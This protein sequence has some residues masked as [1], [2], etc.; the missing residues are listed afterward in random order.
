MRN[1]ILCIGLLGTALFGGAFVISFANPLLVERLGREVVRIEV[2]R[3][4]GA[5]VESLSNSN[6]V[7][8]AQKALARTD[9]EM[10]AVRRQIEA[11][12]PGRVGS[13]IADMLTADCECRKRLVAYA[14]K[15][16]SGR[17]ASL[18]QVRERLTELIEFSYK[19]VTASLMREFRV[20]TA[21]NALVFLA[22]AGLAAWRRHAGTQLVLPAFVLVT[23]AMA[24]AMLYLF[25]QNWLHTI[26]FSDYVGFAYFA[27]LALAVALLSD[28][29]FNKA[30]VSTGIINHAASAVG[31]AF[32]VTPC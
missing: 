4:V 6:L 24:T 13:V 17:L 25:G 3:R 27:Y 29:A 7:G 1:L 2:E 9:D 26:V 8:L 14:E 22:L 12:I 18:S 16:W 32:Q 5:K 19:H 30:R 20:F 15:N 10:V 21:A 11:D 28:I 31:S 23:A